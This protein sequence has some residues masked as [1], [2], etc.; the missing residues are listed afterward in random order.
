MLETDSIQKALK[1]W[2]SKQ[3]MTLGIQDPISIEEQ[4]LD[5]L[6]ELQVK[7]QNIF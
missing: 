2:D 5:K 3:Q 7:G 6:P 1:E 4:T